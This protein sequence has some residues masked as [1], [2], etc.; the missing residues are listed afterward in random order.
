MPR[1]CQ[2]TGAGPRSSRWSPHA[3]VPGRSHP[4]GSALAV[5]RPTPNSPATPIPAARADADNAR[6]KDI[7]SL[8]FSSM[9]QSLPRGMTLGRGLC[10]LCGDNVRGAVQAVT[11][12]QPFAINEIEEPVTGIGRC[13]RIPPP[14]APSMWARRRMSRV[15]PPAEP[16][17]PS[18]HLHGRRVDGH[19][20]NHR[21]HICRSGRR[22]SGPPSDIPWGWSIR[23]GKHQ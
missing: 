5:P 15:W 12:Q 11:D 2:S 6:L 20:W 19:R 4:H 9:R 13:L 22:I 14:G 17:S 8:R 18:P 10:L 16:Q 23:M 7:S 3:G 21:R 1:P